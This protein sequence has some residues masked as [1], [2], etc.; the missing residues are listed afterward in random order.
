[1]ETINI[2]REVNHSVFKDEDLGGSST[3]RNIFILSFT[4]LPEDESFLYII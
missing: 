2:K 1:M 4:K 3:N